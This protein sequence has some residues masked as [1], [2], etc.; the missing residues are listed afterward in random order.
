MEQIEIW[1]EQDRKKRSGKMR[2]EIREWI[3]ESMSTKQQ[4]YHSVAMTNQIERAAVL[5]INTIKNGGTI[6]VCGNGGSASDSAHFVGE[7]LNRFTLKREYP[8]AAID[9]SAQN[10]TITAIANDYSFDDIFAKQ[11]Q[12]LGTDGDMLLAISTSGNSHNVNQA[13]TE[14]NAQGM[15]IVYLTG[16][17]G[18][19]RTTRMQAI[20]V[21]STNTPIIQESHIMIIHILCHLIDEALEGK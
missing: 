6:F 2:H 21:P 10:S 8:L 17:H 18:P 14:A 19:R 9:L 13:V 4:I 16:L 5:M 1:S 12:A 3:Q 11:I 15:E 20:N 7:M